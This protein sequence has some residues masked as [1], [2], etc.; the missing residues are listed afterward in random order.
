[1]NILISIKN[2]DE[3]KEVRGIKGISIIDIKNPAEGTL[4]A[5]HPW[6]IE[7]IKEILNGEMEIAASIGDLDFKPGS[8]SL[9]AFGA[10]SLGL[11]YITAS[12]YKIKSK[13]DVKTMTSKLKKTLEESGSKLIVAGYADFERSGS[14]NPFEFLSY[15]EGADLIMLDTW[16]KDGKN[17]LDFISSEG[18]MD[19]KERSHDLGMDLIIAGSLR[20]PQLELIKEIEPDFL[21]FRGIICEKGSVKRG[22]VKKLV[23]ALN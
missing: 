11:D 3:A 7:E 9:A 2:A 10:A 22:L 18:L 15:A 21:G 14:A 1:L 8:A 12:M 20:F 13:E 4:G 5:N 16:L 19:F 23:E 17:I 6:V